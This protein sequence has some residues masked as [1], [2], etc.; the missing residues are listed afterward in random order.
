MPSD[1]G[2][3]MGILGRTSCVPGDGLKLC[4]Q[5]TEPSPCDILYT[6]CRVLKKPLKYVKVHEQ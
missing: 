2:P 4:Y 3:L 6:T 5:A 1:L